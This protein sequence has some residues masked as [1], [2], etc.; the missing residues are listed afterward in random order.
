M[1][2]MSHILFQDSISEEILYLL[3]NNSLF[4]KCQEQTSVNEKFL[5]EMAAFSL[6]VDALPFS[7]IDFADCDSTK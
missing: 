1:A 4:L 5:S 7:K 3:E 2:V 6:A